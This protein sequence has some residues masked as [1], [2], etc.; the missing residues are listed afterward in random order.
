MRAKMNLAM[1]WRNYL[2]G[3]WLLVCFA[4]LI[5]QVLACGQAADRTLEAECSLLAAGIMVVLSLPLGLIWLW[6]LSGVGYAFA[7]FGM[8]MPSHFGMDL[9]AWVGFVFI[10][11]VQWFICVPW[12]VQKVRSR[13]RTVPERG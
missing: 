7:E 12:I 10:G 13:K 2:K 1:N 6:I 8:Q 5:W 3:V 11:Y 4:V 9:L